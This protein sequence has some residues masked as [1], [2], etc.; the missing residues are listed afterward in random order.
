MASAATALASAQ[1]ALNTMTPPAVI[2]AVTS[3]IVWNNWNM[4][5]SD[6]A[7]TMD[8]GVC[9]GNSQYI[10]S[11]WNQ[12][13]DVTSSQSSSQTWVIWNEDYTASTNQIV[14]GQTPNPD[15]RAGTDSRR[16]RRTATPGTNSRSK[17]Q[18]TRGGR[19][20]KRR[21]RPKRCWSENLD[22]EQRKLFKLG[23]HFMVHS[24]DAK[25]RYKI[26][27][28]TAGNVKLLR[29]DGKAVASFC[30][31]P[32][33]HVPTEDVMLAQK[34]LLETAEDE[35]LRIANRTAISA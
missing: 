25:R 31:H 5:Y 34:L 29:E 17:A 32:E 21:A 26:E 13:Y 9:T 4:V 19:E 2:S 24:R 27:Y 30:I 3:N 11:G 15:C 28:G 33:I 16:A 22:D 6:S 20:E 12:V 23:R 18:R 8:Y 35:F 1:G 10:W 14:Y 7:V